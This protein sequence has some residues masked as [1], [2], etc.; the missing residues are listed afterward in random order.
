MPYQMNKKITKMLLRL[1]LQNCV[2]ANKKI[3]KFQKKGV[4]VKSM[5]Y[6]NFD[7]K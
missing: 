1:V 3:K 4:V 6:E 7:S 5:G 2:F